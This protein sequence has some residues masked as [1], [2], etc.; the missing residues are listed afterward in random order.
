MGGI[1]EV[2]TGRATNPAA[3]TALTM[4]TGDS[5]AVRAFGEAVNVYLENVWTQQATAGFARVRS[6]RMHDNVQGIRVATP[7]ALPLPLLPIEANQRLYQTDTLIA[8]IQGGGAETDAMALQV[9]YDGVSTG[10]ARLAT[11]DQVKSLVKNISGAQ[12]D[13]AGPTT[14]GDWSAGTNLTNFTDQW[15]ADTYYAVLG[16]ELDTASLAVAIKGPD[17][18]NYKVG[19]PGALQPI[20]TRDYFVECSRLTGMPHIPVIQAQ[21]KG[22]TQ[23]HVAKVGAGGTINVTLIVAELSGATGV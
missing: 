8:E 2:I 15:H 17:T 5:L 20:D 9:Y 10:A 11:W 16:Y 7:A 19:G 4:N 21:N 13:V 12:V 3:L 22:N 1:Y 6:P 23:V 14:T 18:G